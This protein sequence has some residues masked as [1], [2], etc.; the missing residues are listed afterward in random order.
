VVAV[1]HETFL[2]AVVLDRGEVSVRGICFGFASPY[3]SIGGEIV[4]LDLFSE[5][6]KVRP[7]QAPDG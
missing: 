6:V 3:S 5:C 4:D 1:E 7:P 2:A